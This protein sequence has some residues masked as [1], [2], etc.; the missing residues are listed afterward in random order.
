MAEVTHS[1]P[2]H[3]SELPQVHAAV[4]RSEVISLHSSPFQAKAIGASCCLGISLNR[5]RRLFPR[6]CDLHGCGL[7]DSGNQ[8]A[9]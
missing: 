1:A 6:S 7:R 5:R 2:Q 8:T 9:H 3:F 4:L